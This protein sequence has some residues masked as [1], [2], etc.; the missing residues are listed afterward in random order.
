MLKDGEKFL[1]EF[2]KKC[3]ISTYFDG[4]VLIPLK[5]GSGNLSFTKSKWN[6]V[7]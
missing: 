1:L 2:L 4:T 5:T 3:T 6:L 7:C